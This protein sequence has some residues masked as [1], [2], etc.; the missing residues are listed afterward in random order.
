MLEQEHTNSEIGV[1][2]DVGST[3]IGV[4]VVDVEHRTELLSFS[5][6]NPQYVYGADVI[7]RIKHCSEKEE[8]QREMQYLVECGLKEQLS[9]RLGEDVSRI[10]KIVYS[11]NTTMLHIL[12]GLSVA[13]LGTAPFTPVDLD[14]AE[15]Q[16]TSK[17]LSNIKH[18]YLPCL[19]A[20]V[21]ADVLAGATHLQMGRKASYELLID[22]GTNGE[23]L[24]INQE[25]GFAT[26]TA[27]GPVFDNVIGGAGYGSDCMKTIANCVRRGLIDS[28][29]KLQEV[30]FDKGI[31]I[32]KNLI[33]KQEH[34]RNFQLA[35]GAIYAGIQCILKQAEIVPEDVEKV[36]ISGGLGFYMNVRDAF[37]L[38]LLPEEFSDKIVISGNTSLEGAKQFLQTENCENWLQEQEGIRKRTKSFELANQKNF[39]E[40]Y[41]TALEWET[42]KGRS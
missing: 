42:A 34:I 7:T 25:K 3:S 2:V 22:L 8:V 32:D 23:L 21:G 38:K 30:L 29:G 11:G 39:Q 18:I 24:L 16:D 31:V 15:I 36:Y 4:C 19:S 28:T 20:F 9:E 40:C 17:V 1:A 37:T 27:C 26:S 41:L 12:R 13:G 14:Y 10:T 5:F 33:V 6:A 35:K